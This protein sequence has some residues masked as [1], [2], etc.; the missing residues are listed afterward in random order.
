MVLF[1]YVSVDGMNM[2]IPNRML[3]G[4]TAMVVYI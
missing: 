3:E 1:V 4:L 2:Q